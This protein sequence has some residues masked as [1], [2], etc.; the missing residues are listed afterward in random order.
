MGGNELHLQ[1]QLKAGER[2]L[3][4]SIQE[5]NKLQGANLQL[6]VELKDV[7]AQLA[8]SVK[9]NRRLRRGIYSK[10]L[11]EL[12]HSSTRR[13]IDRVMSAGMLTG[14]PEEE[15]PGSAGD[16]LQELS[17]LHERARQVMKGIAQ[18]LWPSASLAGGMGKLVE[19]LKGARRRFRLWKVL[20]GNIA[21]IQNFPTCHQDLSME[22]PAMRGRRVH[23]HTLV[24]R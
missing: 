19:M 11:N 10:C 7:R 20:L 18:T 1:G 24:D 9:E 16:M 12:W 6:S 13:R 3:T 23:L 15:M 5:K 14:R 8:D 21:E 4:Q 2:L 17:Q 22:K